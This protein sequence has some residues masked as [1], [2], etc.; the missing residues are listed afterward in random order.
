MPSPA[1]QDTTLGQ[2]FAPPSQNFAHVSFCPTVYF[3]IPP[4]SLRCPFEDFVKHPPPHWSTS[5]AAFG[6]SMRRDPIETH[7]NPIALKNTSVLNARRPARSLLPK[8][9]QFIEKKRV[10]QA[11]PSAAAP[12]PSASRPLPNEAGLR[13]H[14][15]YYYYVEEKAGPANLKSSRNH[16][17]PSALVCA[18]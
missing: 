13:L 8:G 18:V 1:I 11:G 6:F 9:L 2:A 15:G 14:R 3:E 12:G 16:P 5:G 17:A 4:S 7:N 10:L